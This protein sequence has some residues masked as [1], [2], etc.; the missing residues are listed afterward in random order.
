MSAEWSPENF[1]VMLGCFHVVLGRRPSPGQAE[2][3]R[4]VDEAVDPF[5]RDVVARQA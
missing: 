5:M 4:L 3:D 2:I 1:L